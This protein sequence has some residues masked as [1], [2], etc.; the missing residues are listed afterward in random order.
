MPI[1]QTETVLYGTII[2]QGYINRTPFY[3]TLKQDKMSKKDDVLVCSNPGIYSYIQYNLGDIALV[4][5][6]EKYIEQIKALSQNGANIVDN[7]FIEL[8]N[9]QNNFQKIGEL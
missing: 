7:W 5:S 8:T 3:K 1:I 6:M 9:L 4:V 2:N